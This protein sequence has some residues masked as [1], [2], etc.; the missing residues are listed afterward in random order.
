[1][2]AAVTNVAEVERALHAILEPGQ[3]FEIRALDVKQRYG[4]PA[5]VAG[6]FDADHIEEAAQAV[7]GLNGTAKG[8][9]FTPNPCKPDLLA[10]CAYRIDRRGKAD[11]TTSDHEIERRCWLLVDCDPDRP[12]GICSTDAEH[13]AAHNLAQRIKTDLSAAGWP[14]P[15]YSDSGNGAHLMYWIDLPVEDD[16]LVEQCLKALAAKY[17]TAAMKVDT[18]LHNPS[19]I[20]RL[21]GTVNRKGDDTPTRPHRMARMIEAP[22]EKVFTPVELL[23]KLAADAPAASEPISKRREPSKRPAAPDGKTGGT[24]PENSKKWMAGWLKRCAPESVEIRGPEPWQGNGA[25]WTLNPC[26]WNDAHTNDSAFI[27]VLPDGKIGAGCQHNGCSAK[28]W[29]ALRDLWE[30]DRTPVVILPQGEQSISEAGRALGELLAKDERFFIRGGV[31]VKVS[32]DPDGFPQLDEVKAAGLASDF[33]GVAKLVRFEK[34]KGKT[35]DGKDKPAKLQA[36]T[37]CEQTA[38]L[39]AAS[40][41]FRES[42]PPIHVITRC[43]VLIELAGNLFQISGYDRQSGIYAAGKPADPMDLDAALPMLLELVE[44]FRFATPPDRARALAAFITPALVLGGLLRGRAPVDMGEADDSQA[45]KGYRNKLTAAVYAQSVKTVTQKTAGVGSLEES[46]NMALIRGAN[47]VAL[48]NVRGKID[49]PA[50][51]SFLTEDNYTARAPYREP[52]EIDP[53]RVV[54]M[55][56]SNKADVTTDL[57]NRSSCV[58]ILKQPE[59]YTFKLYPE[60]DI[61]D[62]VRA[63]QTQYLGAIF[64][65]VRAWYEAGRPR[66]TETRHDFRPW[67]QSLDWITRNLLDAGPLLD[68]HRETQERMTNPVL[69]WLRDV[70][71]QVVHAKRDREWL[72]TGDMVDLLD[73]AGH[74]PPGVP[75]GA[76]LTDHEVRKTAQQATG[77]KLGVCFRS[78]DT[79]SMDG[80]RI[81]RREEYDP[82]RR[83][84]F[85]LYCFSVAANA[86]PQSAA[87]LAARVEKTVEKT[88]VQVEM[89]LVAA[90]ETLNCGW[91]AAS[92]AANKP[93]IAANAV[94]TPLIA[95]SFTSSASDIAPIGTS[96][97]I[98]RKPAPDDYINHAF[99]MAA[100]DDSGE[101]EEGEIL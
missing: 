95:Q 35:E 84:T 74:L 44:D 71:L 99:D 86:E 32:T 88:P 43:P 59:G 51:E 15:F 41:A 33:E 8:V 56:T 7:A 19:R 30:P 36:S 50:I 9:Y 57:A 82:V 28:D 12:A 69:N 67:A 5:T 94:D 38:K 22:V 45:G 87:P 14:D 10:R 29:K 16:G 81:E 98:S 101:V 21:P 58:R 26:P 2:T 25:R 18:T 42:L 55:F 64:A 53:R 11:P 72:R 24:G 85:R 23:E 78:G 66:T 96:S 70:A 77:R 47:F 3:V 61:L 20:F 49:S 79:V 31:P 80:I 54:V 83:I 17:G 73:E 93:L 100:L 65:I 37:C 40:T 1:M 34:Q 27:V 6:Y 68:G 60:G 39:I 52:V 89:P 13:E 97:R 90:I 63:R 91:S 46:F 76:D 4:A 48:D 75:E 92:P 62:H